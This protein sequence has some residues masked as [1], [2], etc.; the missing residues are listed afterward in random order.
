ML[1]LKKGQSS[2][3]GGDDD[4]DLQLQA[5]TN[6]YISSITVYL[7]L[8]SYSATEFEISSHVPGSAV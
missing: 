3:D 1:V 5:D 4:D 2:N 6:Y 8:R 7:A